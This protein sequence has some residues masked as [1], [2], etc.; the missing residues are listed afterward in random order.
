M[1][2]EFIENVNDKNQVRI[3]INGQMRRKSDSENR[4][5]EK[6]KVIPRLVYV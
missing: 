4:S 1:A 6:S 3:Q 2:L 5:F